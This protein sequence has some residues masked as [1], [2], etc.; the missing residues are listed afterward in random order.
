MAELVTKTTVYGG[1]SVVVATGFGL[2]RFRE[3]PQAAASVGRWCLQT[4]GVPNQLRP[5]ES[6]VGASDRLQ[7]P[8]RFASGG[9]MT[10]AA[11]VT[12]IASMPHGSDI[13]GADQLGVRVKAPTRSQYRAFT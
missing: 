12:R 2:T 6:R 7:S 11:V 4:T 5:G 9:R 3:G 10:L 8:T 13:L 1:A